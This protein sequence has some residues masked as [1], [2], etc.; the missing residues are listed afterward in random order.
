VVNW[1][2]SDNASKR[3]STISRRL[4]AVTAPLALAVVVG[5]CAYP[6]TAD[7]YYHGQ[8]Q[9]P[10]SVE[11]GVVENVRG[12]ALQGPN[13]G[14]GAFGGSV[15]GGVA[16]SAIGQGYGSL[17]AAVGGAILGGIIGNTVEANAARAPGVEVTIRLDNGR[18]LA[19]VQQDAGEAFRPGD[20]V[21]IVS[22]GYLTRVTR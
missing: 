21:R 2:M 22:D 10:Q 19:V 1:D 3:P 8:V 4:A 16:G 13:T 12:V 6:M 11:L 5:G 18:M 7:T 17:A 9:R 20:R 14:A 15:L